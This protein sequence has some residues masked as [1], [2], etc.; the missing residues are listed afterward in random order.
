MRALLTLA[1]LGGCFDA[2]KPDSTV[3]YTGFTCQEYTEACDADGGHTVCWDVDS[4]QS[5]FAYA[6]QC[7]GTED[8]TGCVAA[9]VTA[10]HGTGFYQLCAS[11]TSADDNGAVWPWTW[12][13]VQICDPVT[14]TAQAPEDLLS[15]DD[16]IED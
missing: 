13:E 8:S 15:V 5:F 2:N 9:Y 3:T 11:C 16:L 1:L 7:G 12:V 14:L 10:N 4:T 6:N